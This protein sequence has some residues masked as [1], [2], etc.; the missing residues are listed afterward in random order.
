ML[1]ETLIFGEVKNNKFE[2]RKIF[3]TKDDTW[4][5]APAQPV[6]YMKGCYSRMNLWFHYSISKHQY[7]WSLTCSGRWEKPQHSSQECT[8]GDT[9]MLPVQPSHF[10]K[11][12]RLCQSGC[13]LNSCC[14]WAES[15]GWAVCKKWHKHLLKNHSCTYISPKRQT[16]GGEIMKNWR[17]ID[18]FIFTEET[19]NFQAHIEC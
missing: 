9:L 19:L 13:I 11:G 12:K 6:V 10:M 5:R 1:V 14:I 4:N 15:D 2:Q 3:C 7:F 8:A 17:K 16:K 18:S